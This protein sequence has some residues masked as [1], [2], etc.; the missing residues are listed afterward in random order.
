MTSA[1]SGEATA[2]V[3][4]SNGRLCRVSLL[5]VEGGIITQSRQLALL[6]QPP[7]LLCPSTFRTL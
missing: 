4:I 6:A 5:R 2:G 7:L 1:N 3:L